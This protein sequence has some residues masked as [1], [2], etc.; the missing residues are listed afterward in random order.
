M[1]HLKGPCESMVGEGTLY[2]EFNGE[3]ATR[4][5]ECYGDTWFSSRQDYYEDKGPGLF[6]GLLSDL[7][8][9][10]VIEITAKEF[11]QVWEASK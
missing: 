8:L 9:S 11:E 5:V 3:H 10:E 2:I 7:D 4:Q 6:D 1:K